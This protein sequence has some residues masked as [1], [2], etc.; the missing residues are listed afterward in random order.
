MFEGIDAHWIWLTIGLVL[1][2]LEMLVPGVFLLWLGLAAVVTSAIAFVFDLG[3]AFQVVNFVFL[4]LIAVYS[5]K[6]FLRERPIESSD[7][8]LNKRGGRLVGETAIVTQAL[9]GGSGRIRYGD[10]EW[11]ARGPDIDVGERV[12]IT[13]SNGAELLVEPLNLIEGEAKPAGLAPED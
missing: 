7:P 13:G 12:R 6:R 11:I 8:L 10:S 5:A 3:P 9:D 1:I 4:S 2:A